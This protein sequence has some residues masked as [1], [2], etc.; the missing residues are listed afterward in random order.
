MPPP[1]SEP[2]PLYQILEEVQGK[3]GGEGEILASSHG[4]KFPTSVQAKAEP[5]IN[6]SKTIG[7]VKASEKEEEKRKKE[8]EKK[9]KYKV[10]F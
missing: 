7:D 2:R 5:E 3:V 1:P 6:I 9:E 10:K 8:K 4:Y